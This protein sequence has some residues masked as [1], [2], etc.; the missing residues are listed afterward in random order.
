MPVYEFECPSCKDKDGNP[1][2]IGIIL[3]VADR[4][5]L[6]VCEC[7]KLMKRKFSTFSF[8]FTEPKRDS[9]TKPGARR[10]QV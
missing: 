10:V 2:L 4:D 7:G 5:R 3:L 9:Q 1:L 8:S 6:Q